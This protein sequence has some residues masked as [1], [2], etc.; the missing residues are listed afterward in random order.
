MA[1]VAQNR[2]G[3]YVRQ[4]TGYRAFIPRPLPPVP[5][6]QLSGAGQSLLSAA[7]IALGR[8]DGS[9]EILPDADLFMYM[10]IRK[11]AVLSSRIEG[12]QSSLNDLLTAEAKL[13]GLHNRDA[14]SEVINHVRAVNHG[15]VRL[16]A[17]PLSIRLIKEIH[18]E[19][20]QGTRG[21]QY[22]PGQIRTSQN[23]IGPSGC[24][25]NE[26][27]FVPPPPHLVAEN[28]GD[29]ESFWHSDSDLPMLI[30]VALAHA[31]FETIHPFLDGNGR[32]GRL[33]INFLLIESEILGKPALFLSAYFL[34][35]R[36]DYYRLLQA[37]RDRGSWEDWVEFFLQ[38]VLEV[39]QQAADSARRILALREDHRRTVAATF[40]RSAGNGLRLLEYLYRSP[41]LSVNQV[42]RFTGIR[43]RSANLLIARFV[44]EGLLEEITGNKRN[45][46]FQYRPYTD[47]FAGDGADPSEPRS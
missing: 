27:I 44:E 9:I 37:I 7:D 22:Q 38:G 43:F 16:R 1:D 28:L 36:D 8:L 39:S 6:L 14:V 29:L 18:K 33:L 40:G 13:F 19:L 15:I 25:L 34:R 21:S 20:I 17:L 47:I 24:A 45:R 46:L 41:V 12:T 2:A 42:C 10:F 26:A 35:H 23:W 30:K 31:Q 3:Q 4:P 11:E 5:P 32:I